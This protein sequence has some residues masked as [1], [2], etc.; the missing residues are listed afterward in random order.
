MKQRIALL[1][2]LLTL[3]G[4]YLWWQGRPEGDRV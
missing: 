4:G 1:A 3:I 2:V